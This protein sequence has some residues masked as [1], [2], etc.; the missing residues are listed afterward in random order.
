MSLVINDLRIKNIKYEFLLSLNA[1]NV[2]RLKQKIKHSDYKNMQ[3]SGRYNSYFPL[4][5]T[6]SMNN[7]F[8]KYNKKINKSAEI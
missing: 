4:V 8:E 5:C 3:C 6:Q 1:Q 2:I 7:T